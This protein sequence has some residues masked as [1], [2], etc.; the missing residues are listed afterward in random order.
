MYNVG[1]VYEIIG[2]VVNGTYVSAY[3]LRDRRNQQIQPINKSIVEQLALNKQ[4]YNCQAQVY[5]KIVNLKGINCKLSKLPKYDNNG[6]IIEEKKNDSQAKK[7]ADLQIIGKVLDGRRVKSYVICSIAD[8]SKKI[9]LSRT[10]TLKLVDSGR[11]LNAKVQRNAGSIV[12]RGDNG[13]SLTD[14]QVYGG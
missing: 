13:F 11:V 3:I 2:R 8:K 14:I 1:A 5:D 12:L 10:D 4:I 6:N 9:T 7:K